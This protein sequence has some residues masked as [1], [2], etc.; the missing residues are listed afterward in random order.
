MNQFKIRFSLRYKLLLMLIT[1][2]LI[3]LGLYLMM[4]TDLFQADKVA[5]VYDSS[6]TVSRGLST[7]MRMETENAYAAMRTVVENFD[8]ASNDFNAVAKDLFAKNKRMYAVLL[9]RRNDGGEYIRVGQLAKEESTAQNFTANVDLLT[10]LRDSAVKNT[11]FVGEN[12]EAPGAISASFRLG[13]REELNH[14]VVMGLYQAKDLLDTFSARGMYSSFVVT[15]SGQIAIGAMDVVGTDLDVLRT[16]LKANSK[17]GTAETRLSDGQAYLI[18]YSDVELGDLTVISKVDK[19]KALKAVEVLVIKSL[20]FF[21][22]LLASTLLISVFA[23]NAMTSTLRELLDATSKIASGDFNVKIKARSKDEVGGL[24]ENFNWMAGEVSRLM[25]ATA[26]KARM[27][28]E[29]STV[30]TVQE[31]LFP[32]ASSQF[33]PIRIR[34]HFEPASECGGDWWNYS[35]SGNKI[36]LWIGDATGHGAPAALITSAARSAAAVI[37][38]LPDVTPGKAL[39]I[40]NRAIHQTSKGQIMMTFF[41]ACIDLDANT[42]SYASASHDPPYLLRKNPAA[43][44]LSKKDLVPLNEVNGPRLGDQKDFQYPET[45]IAFEPGDLLF[46]YTDGILDVE[47]PKGK[48][49][50]ERAFLKCLID[51]A[52]NGADVEVKLEAIRAQIETYRSGSSLIDD[53]TMVMCEYEKRAA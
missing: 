35:R 25:N 28:S 24:A 30:R 31:T 50:G 38:S 53:V 12:I 47:D 36:F 26:E 11:V 7:Q 41:I 52:N 33:G 29:L 15:R 48:K 5:Y 4:A 20:L 46:L 19:K 14:M 6:A 10:R 22:A 40:L 2:P 18:S 1:L 51:S 16:V 21:A 39:S 32:P 43:E 34:G 8:F 27:E 9:F 42:F 37:E 13:N 44:K 23:S 45:T 3:S 17:E 49:W